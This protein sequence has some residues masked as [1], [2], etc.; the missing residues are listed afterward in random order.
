MES[1][2]NTRREERYRS[3]WQRH[4]LSTLLTSPADDQSLPTCPPLI[5]DHNGLFRFSFLSFEFLTHDFVPQPAPASATNVGAVSRSPRAAPVRSSASGTTAKQR[6]VGSGSSSTASRRP[7]GAS[8]G[9][10]RF[11]TDDSPGIKV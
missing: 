10:W 11:Y 1:E 6:K 5:P 4:L 7:T 8:S 9:M 3:R 2:R